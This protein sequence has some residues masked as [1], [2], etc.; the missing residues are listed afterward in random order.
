[1]AKKTPERYRSAAIPFLINEN[2]FSLDVICETLTAPDLGYWKES[3]SVAWIDTPNNKAR[4]DSSPPRLSNL[5]ISLLDHPKAEVHVDLRY[6]CVCSLTVDFRRK[7]GGEEAL[8]GNL[9]VKIPA[10]FQI[11]SGTYSK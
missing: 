10:V 4:D 8:R 3:L 9:I 6:S 1:M 2:Y 11:L 5:F 7:K